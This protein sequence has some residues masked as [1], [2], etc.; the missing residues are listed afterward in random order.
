MS[1]TKITIQY[2]GQN[3]MVHDYPVDTQNLLGI[4]FTTV[5]GKEIDVNFSTRQDGE[6]PGSWLV[7]RAREGH[8][9]LYPIAANVVIVN[10]SM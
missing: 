1:E 8:L 9:I 3:G 4:R 5:D 10:A 2:L 6:I 7:V